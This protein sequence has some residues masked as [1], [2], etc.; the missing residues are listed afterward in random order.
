MKSFDFYLYNSSSVTE[1]YVHILST[2]YVDSVL[3][4]NK[5]VWKFANCMGGDK[6]MAQQH[7]KWPVRSQFIRVF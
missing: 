2:H 6:D 3:R 5:V 7:F 4:C 1:S